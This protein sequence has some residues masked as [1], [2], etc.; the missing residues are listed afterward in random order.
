MYNLLK[1]YVS[2]RIKEDGYVEV[3]TPQLVDR[4]LWEASGHWEKYRENMFIAES[5]NRILAVKPMNC[6][7]AVQ[8]FKYGINY[9][10]N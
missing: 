4:S 5:E 6:P 7:G 1:N 3:C 2:E 8:I 9:F 10:G